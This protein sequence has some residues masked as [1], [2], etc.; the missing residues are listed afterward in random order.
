MVS[1]GHRHPDFISN[2][3][4]KRRFDPDSG[5]TYRARKLE[6]V[7]C[8]YCSHAVSNQYLPTYICHVHGAPPDVSTDC[9]DTSP[10]PCKHRRT[11]DPPAFLNYYTIRLGPG[12]IV[13]PVPDCPSHSTS[14]YAFRRHLCNQHLMDHFRLFDDSTELTQC[15]HCGL[16]LGHLTPRHIH[17]QFCIR[18]SAH[19]ARIHSW[20]QCP[21]TVD[22]ST[23]FHIGDRRIEYVSKF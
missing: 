11:S 20:S 18:Q 9:T 10:P 3:M 15:P 22:T 17:S 7:Q 23:P 21:V 13:C 12:M 14:S 19:R 5:P 1:V 6:K 16:F 2:V 4:F 8:P